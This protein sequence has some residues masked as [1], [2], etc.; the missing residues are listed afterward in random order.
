LK[1]IA[2]ACDIGSIKAGSFAWA[3][4][5]SPD[6]TPTASVDID[7]L[8][9]SIVRDANAGMTIAIGFEA[10]LFMP[11]PDVS[12]DLNSGRN[13]ESSRSMFA[14]AGAAVTTIAIHETAWILKRLHGFVGTR[15]TLTTD[16]RTNWRSRAA[17]LFMW[18]AFVSSTA[19]SDTHERDA[20]TALQYFLNNDQDLN[21]VNAVT[22][23]NPLSLIAA[24][25]LWSGWF[26]DIQSLKSSCL[27][28]R[29]TSP[30]A[31]PIDPA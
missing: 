16:W 24:S 5:C 6:E 4:N 21:A 15:L 31:G 30:Y 18:E 3:R 26:T 27:V 10:P 19:H 20:A 1:A 14:P 17:H 11:V 12:S 2:Y 9:V 7:D 28:L 13:N 23:D 25:A 29:P 22:C 8:I